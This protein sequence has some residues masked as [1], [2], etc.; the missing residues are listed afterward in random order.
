MISISNGSKNFAIL[1]QFLNKNDFSIFYL[2]Y[3]QTFYEDFIHRFRKHK[4]KKFCFVFMN[5]IF[6]IKENVLF[7]FLDNLKKSIYITNFFNSEF[8][9]LL[10]TKT[11]SISKKR[12]KKSYKIIK[13]T[14]VATIIEIKPLLK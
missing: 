10:E 8:I 14:Y 3:T 13:S 9:C 1:L 12:C 6:F 7:T 2:Y 5:Y 11:Y 4:Q